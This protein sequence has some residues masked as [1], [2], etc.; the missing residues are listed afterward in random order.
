MRYE[1]KQI[2]E[3]TQKAIK[4]NETLYN[5]KFINYKSKTS[6]TKVF[7]TEIIASEISNSIINGKLKIDTFSR[8][9]KSYLINNHQNRPVE[10]RETNREEE[11]CAKRLFNKK[12][13]DI[14][15]VIDFQTPLKDKQLDKLGKI[16]LIISNDNNLTLYLIEL[17]FGKNK[18]TL[19]RAI[20]EAYTYY[21]IIDE[22]KL[23]S[24][25][26]LNHMP[27]IKPAVMV[28]GSECNSY[29]ELENINDRPE[30]L[31]LAKKLDITFFKS[32]DESN[33]E[34]FS[35]ENS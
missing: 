25:F 21:K 3:I 2:Q 29:K 9:S 14:G 10:I 6:D 27:N 22:D 34:I 13:L 11:K 17:K 4:N 30:L 19:L 16:D 5:Q 23:K 26:K 1:S 24:D 28:I 33:F 18:E 15:E 7:C 35:A 8:N 20:L 31:K 12:K 32:A